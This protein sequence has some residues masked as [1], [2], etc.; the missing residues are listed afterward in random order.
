MK[1]S[2]LIAFTALAMAACVQADDKKMAM[3][4]MK[5]CME[6][7]DG[8]CM[9]GKEMMSEMKSDHAMK[10]GEMMK[11]NAMKS[12]EMMKSDMQMKSDK[13][14]KSGEMMKSDAKMKADTMMKPEMKGEMKK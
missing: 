5:P 13:M 3:E 10:K 4:S 8:K 7:K 1:K 14:M 9:Q 6:M 12:G 11:D 2:M